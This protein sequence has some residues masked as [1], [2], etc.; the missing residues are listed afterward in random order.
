MHP[1][2]VPIALLK[3]VEEAVAAAEHPVS[4]EWINRTTDRPLSRTSVA[5]LRRMLPL[6]QRASPSVRRLH[7]SAGL[8]LRF[9]SA[10]DR[11]RVLGRLGRE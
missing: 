11:R 10:D 8:R 9:A 1:Y 4:I 3:E 5:M 7:Q 6:P 2:V